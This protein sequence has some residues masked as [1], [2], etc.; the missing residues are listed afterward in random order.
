LRKNVLTPLKSDLAFCGSIAGDQNDI[1]NR[2]IQDCLFKWIRQEPTN[3]AQSCD[4]IS[5]DDGA[6]RIL[7]KLHPNFLGGA[8]YL[9]SVGS[10]L[11][12][13]YWREILRANLETQ[14]LESYEWFVVTR[15]DFFWKVR[16]PRIESLN[17]NHIY[18]LDGEKYGGL[19]DRHIIFHRKFAKK[20]LS[21]AS[22]IFESATN[23]E[24]ALKELNLD[25][26]NPEIY[27]SYMLSQKDLINHVRFLPYLG[28]TI[29][30]KETKTRW[31]EGVFNSK[32]NLYLKY[33]EEYDASI[34]NSKRFKFE[35]QW[36]KYLNSI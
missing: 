25:Y 3:W 36:K 27:L 8:D 6:W 34:L 30:Q 19:S 5:K 17:E 22:P 9:D 16:H 35:F 1:D 20:I 24:Q 21:V 7:T 12:I 33:P 14:I 32:L 4:E 26:I 18:F 10:G 13:M 29:R 11:I 2:V 23:L 31:S 28:Y 15:S